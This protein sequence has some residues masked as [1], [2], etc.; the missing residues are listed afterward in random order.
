MDE[1]RCIARDNARDN[2]MHARYLRADDL[3]VI[4]EIRAN[5]A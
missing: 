1:I 2:E 3:N 4:F 5:K